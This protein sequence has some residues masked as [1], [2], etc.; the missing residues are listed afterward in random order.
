MTEVTIDLD[1]LEALVYVSSAIK[2]IES[3]LA[4]YK[5]DPFV[6]K[7]H[8]KFG[9]AQKRLEDVIRRARRSERSGETEI[10]YDGPLDLEEEAV[11]GSL[12]RRRDRDDVV[13]TIAVEEKLQQTSDGLSP[14]DR[15]AAK[16]MIEVGS[17]V[18]GAKWTGDGYPIIRIDATRYMVRFT[19]RGESKLNAGRAA[20]ER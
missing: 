4:A 16:G 9:A 14:I 17:Y 20:Q 5:R 3:A 12:W 7:A 1:D 13:T 19:T 2:T 11:L 18:Y 10:A 15:L 6:Q 8:G